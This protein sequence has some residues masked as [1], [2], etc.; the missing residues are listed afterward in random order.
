MLQRFKTKRSFRNRVY[1]FALVI[2]AYIIMQAL[3]MAGLL[4]STMQGLL[5][6]VCTYI[7]MAL[8]L[9]L[10]V[11][12]L[13][14]LSL[15]HAGFMSVGA[16]SAIVTATAL[17]DVIPIDGLRFAVSVVVAA[18][19]AAVTGVVIGIPVLRLNGDY[20]AIVTLAFG[21]I[22]K[23][24]ITNLYVGVDARGVHFA[25]L[26]QTLLK[27]GEG[28]RLVINGPMGITSIQKI[29]T[30]TYGFILIILTLLII[31]NLVHSRAGRAV[32]ALRDNRIAA[33]SIGINVTKYKMMA[34]VISAGI[35]GAAGAL[36]GQCQNTIV[37]S[38]FNFDTSIQVLMFV[39]LGGMGSMMG[40]VIAATVLTLLP[41]LLRN[42]GLGDYRMLIYAV[43]LILM[44]LFNSAPA[45][46][47]WREKVTAKAKKAL[48][49]RKKAPADNGK[50]AA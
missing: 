47:E 48:A 31:F 17:R 32:M 39:V 30:F 45:A 18:V 46:L 9:N 33:E 50:G 7:L 19:L 34:F 20:L 23:S 43:V 16:F 8:S 15:G 13:G 35:A 12:I 2:A 4:N 36:Y 37:A 10:T 38:K 27:L 14:E 40:S 29:S 24:I 28:G 21:E 1:T 44:M 3:S 22:I 41:E 26:D 49:A 11:G 25:F 5:L 42:F 6:P